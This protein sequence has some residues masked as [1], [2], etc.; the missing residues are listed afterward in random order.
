MASSSR[1]HRSNAQCIL[2]P[3]LSQAHVWDHIPNTTPL[4]LVEISSLLF[5]QTLACRRGRRTA[6]ASQSSRLL[7]ERVWMSL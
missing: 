2:T 1:V 3:E 6:D 7:A 4:I 5:F